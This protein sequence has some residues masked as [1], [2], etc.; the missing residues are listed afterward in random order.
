MMG[1][2]EL[3]EFNKSIIDEFRANEGV[4]GGM[5][6][7]APVLLLSSVGAKSG[8]SRLN[9]LVYLSDGDRVIIFASYEGQPKN[10]PWY[11]NLLANPE[12]GVEIGTEQYRA[13]ATVLDEPERS[14]L[15]AKMEEAMPMFTDYKNKTSRV[16]PVI[17]L[18]RL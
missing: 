2:D 5:F 8:E 16:I 4:L 13:S 10:P 17:A 6:E 12:V 7:G 18:T 15:Y 9:P 14:E 11:Y 3:R 1:A